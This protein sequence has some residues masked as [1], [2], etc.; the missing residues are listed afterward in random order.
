[1][2]ETVDMLDMNEHYNHV[3][4]RL[5]FFSVDQHTRGWLAVVSLAGLL[6]LSPYN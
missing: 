5:L 1:M 4:P 2:N 6:P 3:L